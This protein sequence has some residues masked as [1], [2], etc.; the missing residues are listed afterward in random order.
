MLEN[1]PDLMPL[2]QVEEILCC[3]HYTTLRLVNEGRIA[4]FKL[5]GRWLVSK[6]SLID[7][8]EERLSE[9]E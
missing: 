1:F 2:K 4:G 6:Q 9:R 3:R 5:G 8:I 7:Y